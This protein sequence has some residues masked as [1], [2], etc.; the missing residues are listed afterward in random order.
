MKVGGPSGTS[1]THR[2]ERVRGT[3][4]AGTTSELGAPNA[5]RGVEDTAAI[6]G[7]APEEMTP[8]IRDAILSLK[9][10][11]DSLRHELD[12][13]HK[14]LK[15]MEKLV[16][17]DPMIP[18]LNRRAF[19]REVSRMIS[20]AERY[21]TPS[22]LVYLDVNNLKRINDD[23]GHAAGDRALLKIAE[24]LAAQIRDTDAIGRI[25]GDEFGILLTH[26]DEKTAAEKGAEL[27]EIIKGE[28][29]VVDGNRIPLSI[30]SGVY[31][32]GAGDDPSD[33]LAAADQRMYEHK[34]RQTKK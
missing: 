18:I 29:L 12:E 2:T 24:V 20:Y 15:T 30:S 27:V 4:T 22:S 26:A 6:M 17:Q 3:E 31:A 11:V 33:A 34:R 7:I 19:V 21:G 28:R 10:E 1:G 8:K 25:G 13:A 5:V 16:D 32:F 23:F 14:R 9:K